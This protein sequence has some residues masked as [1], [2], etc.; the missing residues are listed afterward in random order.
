VKKKISIH[1]IARDLKI[2][3]ASVSYVLNG[4]A[5]EKRIGLALEKKI[6]DYTTKIGYEP[7]LMAKTLR[8]GKS[9]IIGM[10]VEDISDPFFSAIARQVE[11]RSANLGYKILYAST[12]N[13]TKVTKTLLQLFRQS[14]VDGYIIAPPPGVEEDIKKL[15][16]DKVPIV[17][18]DRHFEELSTTNVLINNAEGAYKGVVHLI[19]NGYKNIAFITL[20]SKQSQMMER[21]DGYKTAMKQ[22]KLKRN[23]L[24]IPYRSEPEKMFESMNNHLMKYP[25]IDAVFF[26][27]NYLA[28][29]GL[30]VIKKLGRQM[31]NKLALVSFDDSIH[32]HL[33]TPSLT[34]IAQPIDEISETITNEI[35]RQLSNNKADNRPITYRLKTHL[36]QR[37]SS[38]KNIG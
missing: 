7:N 37:D 27:T 35:M 23:E 13:N 3:A 18:F 9:H 4:L 26:A 38:I 15:V 16:T 22:H 11:K 31:P 34:A 19:E 36:I 6:L 24:K 1:D 30:D 25:E 17:L 28:L 2:S 32:F 10:L 29:G 5:R 33:L 20:D 12:E 8:T 21:L 14:R